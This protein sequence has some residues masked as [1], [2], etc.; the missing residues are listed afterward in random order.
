[1]R[2]IARIDT[3]DDARLAATDVVAEGF[4]VRGVP[5]EPSGCWVVVGAR[6]AS[7]E[8]ELERAEDVLA[9]RVLDHNAEL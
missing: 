2:F 8:H 5:R 7:T 9:E 1:M 3:E 6:Y 4:V